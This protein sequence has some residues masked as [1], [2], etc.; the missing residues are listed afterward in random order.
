M[1][2]Q[3]EQALF[4]IAE[5]DV[6][7]A[8]DKA[9]PSIQEQPGDDKQAPSLPKKRKKR[10]HIRFRLGKSQVSDA[11]TTNTS[12]VNKTTETCSDRPTSALVIL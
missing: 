10:K 7:T 12:I 5:T 1:S 9:L 11:Q 2:A 6:P 4:A 8:E 3:D